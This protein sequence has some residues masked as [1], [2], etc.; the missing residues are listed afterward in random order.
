MIINISENLIACQ[1]LPLMNCVKKRASQEFISRS[2]DKFLFL[3]GGNVF[4]ALADF[5]D[6]LA[7]IR[8]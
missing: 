3:C 4:S 1:A 8:I 6:R 2:S 7:H 5:T